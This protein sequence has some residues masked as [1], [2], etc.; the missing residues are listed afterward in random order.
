[1]VE[2]Q[3]VNLG[4]WSVLSFSGR[5]EPFPPQAT[6]TKE[7]QTDRDDELSLPVIGDFMG[8]A[9]PKEPL[10]CFSSLEM[11]K[12]ESVLFT[13]IMEETYKCVTLQKS[14]LKEFS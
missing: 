3:Q 2:N 5:E 14:H 10:R 6:M 13:L 11:R 1:M 9:F 12:D 8:T 4:L 7:S